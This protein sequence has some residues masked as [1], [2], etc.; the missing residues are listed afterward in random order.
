MAHPSKNKSKMT[1]KS[2][3]MIPAKTGTRHMAPWD[4]LE[5]GDWFTPVADAYIMAHTRNKLDDDYQYAGVQAGGLNCVVR[6]K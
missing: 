6:V 4:S 5:I 3:A 2:H 1:G